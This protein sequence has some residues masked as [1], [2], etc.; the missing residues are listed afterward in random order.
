MNDRKG[1]LEAYDAALSERFTHT[2]RYCRLPDYKG[3]R[4]SDWQCDELMNRRIIAFGLAVHRFTGCELCAEGL[5]CAAAVAITTVHD[6]HGRRLT[7]KA[8][9]ARDARPPVVT[10]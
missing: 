1:L 6:R 5:V 3:V 9:A 10:P 8:A 2:H 7:A 4:H